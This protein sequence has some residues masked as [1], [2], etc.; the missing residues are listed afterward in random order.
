METDTARAAWEGQAFLQGQRAGIN[1]FGLP[2]NV[3]DF[4]GG[5]APELGLDAGDG[6]FDLMEISRQREEASQV[7]RTVGGSI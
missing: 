2:E 1:E 3:R 4:P 6:V 5:M 7:Q